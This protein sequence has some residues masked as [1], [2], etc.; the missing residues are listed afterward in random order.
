MR[1]GMVARKTTKARR[2][3][4]LKTGCIDT[5]CSVFWELVQIGPRH[6][7]CGMGPKFRFILYRTRP[8]RCSILSKMSV[9]G[10]NN[11]PTHSSS[12]HIQRRGFY[13][14]ALGPVA[15]VLFLL[16]TTACSFFGGNNSLPA[17][18]ERVEPNDQFFQDG[19]QWN[20]EVIRMPEAWWL[21]QHP[22]VRPHLRQVT[23]AVVDSGIV[24]DHP[25]F[26]TFVP[27]WDF[28]K[29]ESIPETGI[30]PND[31]SFS[32][33][34]HVAGV[35]AALTNNSGEGIASVGWPGHNSVP[36]IQIMPIR[37][38]EATVDGDGKIVAITGTPNNL[39]CGI[40][41]AVGLDCDSVTGSPTK[42]QVVNLSL[43]GGSDLELAA[44]FEE[45]ANAGVTIV[46]AAG[47]SGVG[48][49]LYPARYPDTI[50]VG[51]VNLSSAS[52]PLGVYRS[53]FSNYGEGLDL[54]APGGRR[55]TP[56]VPGVWSTFINADDVLGYGAI[57]G[58][59]MAAPHVSAVA[60]LLY[61]VSPDMDQERVRSIL[62][63]TA[64]PVGPT[65]EYGAGVLDAYEAVRA[66]LTTAYGGPFLSQ[67]LPSMPASTAFYPSLSPTG[68][69]SF[70]TGERESREYDNLVPL[71]SISP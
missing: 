3:R 5:H 44:L 16:S 10:R 56:A 46:A 31:S 65:L 33:G 32:H 37:V 8:E 60:A 50:A 70:S 52:D 12:N 23:V 26:G 13:W 53:G 40:K 18:A 25:D 58:T 64:R 61:A 34:A 55:D 4:E 7:R 62:R 14:F 63:D 45:A 1:A 21:L 24:S 57:Q 38:L 67:D 22:D 9:Q 28:I 39:E 54:V 71:P 15:A 69:R 59:S 48:S 11:R 20:M 27:G 29:S 49:L 47:N 66:A 68:T 6:C 35:I 2:V 19:S 36:L 42:A 41:F 43:G 17:R 30:A 51:S